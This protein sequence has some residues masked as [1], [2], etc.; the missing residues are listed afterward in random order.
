MIALMRENYNL[1]ADGHIKVVNFLA[2]QLIFGYPRVKAWIHL[3]R[4]IATSC[5]PLK[6]IHHYIPVATNS[7][8]TFVAYQIHQALYVHIQAVF[9]TLK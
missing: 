2:V 1:A 4:N 9:K 5:L 3:L 7:P 6:H 8:T